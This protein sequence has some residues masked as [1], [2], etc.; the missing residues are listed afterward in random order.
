MHD[1]LPASRALFRHQTERIGTRLMQKA[2][3]RDGVPEITTGLCFLLSAALIYAQLLLPPRSPG[4]ITACLV[5]SFGLPVLIFGA[6]KAIT[7]VRNRY[8]IRRVGYVKTKAMQPKTVGIGSMF[9]ILVAILLF[10]VVPRLAQSQQWLLASAG[11]GG[12]VMACLC[13][14]A[15]RFFLVGGIIAFTGIAVALSPVSLTAG[16]AILWCVTGL[17]ILVSG[18]LVFARFLRLPRGN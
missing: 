17:A 3:K 15:P 9:A 8:L 1:P 14:R 16:F 13:G 4:F 5:F 10:G 7:L 18:S 12:G 6:P 11:F 2:H